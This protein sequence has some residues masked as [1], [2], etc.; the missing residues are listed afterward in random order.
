[1]HKEHV[2]KAEDIGFCKGNCLNALCNDITIN[3]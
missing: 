1:M 3:M 2:D